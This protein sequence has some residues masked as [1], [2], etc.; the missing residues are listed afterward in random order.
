MV[1]FNTETFDH[2]LTGYPLTGAHADQYCEDCHK[3]EFIAGETI[4]DKQETYLGL[5]TKCLSCHADYHQESLSSS[6]LNCHNDKA[7]RPAPKFNHSTAKFKL[8]GKHA[9][10]E[11][12]KCHKIIIRNGNEYQ[13]FTGISYSSCANCH[14]DPHRNQFGQNCS[15]CHTVESFLSVREISNFD[16]SR[17]G[18]MLED[19]HQDLSCK[20]CHK[21][22]ITDPVKHQH[23]SDCHSDYHENQFATKGINIDCAD[24]HN[25]SGFENSSFTVERHNAG[26]YQ[27]QGGHLA[28][29][30]FACHKKQEKWSFQEIGLRCSECHKNIHESYIDQKYY[31]GSDCSTCHSENG[32]GLV[33]FDHSKT[34]FALEGT[35]ELQT[36]RS[37]HYRENSAGQVQQKFSGLASNC[38]NC[39]TDI[40][41]NQFETNNSVNCFR[42]H[43]PFGWVIENFNHNSAAFRLEGKHENISCKKCH[44]EI[45]EGQETF[46]LYKIQEFRCENC[47]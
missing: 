38:T 34:Q 44:K 23:C 14:S 25:T 39:H 31:P 37:C 40:H 2:K 24:C 15:E 16:H 4:R 5:N 17:T 27:L 3:P 47:H 42:C 28:T 11:C 8:E 43:N 26:S 36:C 29:P 33:R 22:N 41:N 9:D 46:I 18:F 10:I 20:S 21:S 7:F 13:A 1:R 45:S 19:K 30:C 6:C 12:A 35:H 32:W